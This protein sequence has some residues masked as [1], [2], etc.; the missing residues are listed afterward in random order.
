MALYKY[1]NNLTQSSD[2]AFDQVHDPGISAPY[3]GIYRCTKCGHEIGIAAGHT[4]PP[5]PHPQH[6][7]HLGPIQWKLLIY[8][9]H[10][11]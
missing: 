7:A 10:N 5:Q 9:Q 4:L 6:P 11:Q 8:A 1:S 3:A 2:N